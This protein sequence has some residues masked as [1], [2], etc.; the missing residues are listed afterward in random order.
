[1]I[2]KSAER[3]AA[4]YATPPGDTLDDVLQTMGMTQADLSRRMGRPLKTVNEI[5]KGK[6]AITPDTAL[7]LER[8]LGIPAS[9]WNNRERQY[10]G[11]LAQLQEQ[12]ANQQ[13][14]SWL[15]TIPV[16][17][18]V[19]MGWIGNAE[20]EPERRIEVL[21][22]FGVAGRR[23]WE[24]LWAAPAVSFRRSHVFEGNPGAVSAWL[25]RGE[26][27][28][29]STDCSK[30]DPA[31]FRQALRN[32]RSMTNEYPEQFTAKIGSECAKGGVA[33]AFVPEIKGAPMSG[34]TRWLT[35]RK[36]LIQLSLRYKTNDHLWFSLFHEAGHILLHGKRQVFIED[37]EV[38]QFE[39]EANEFACDWLLEPSQYREFAEAGDFTERA[40]R[41]F[42]E[43]QNIAPGIVVGRLQHDGL[44]SFSRLN[45]LKVKYRWMTRNS[46]GA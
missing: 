20:T 17:E 19:R 15:R 45:H 1:M 33:I 12:T 18:M 16:A 9:F 24:Q 34:A 27:L 7:Q 22:F 42:A 25:R 8:V 37:A 29:Q 3:Y 39:E 40:V 23:Q 43:S 38:D 26:I 14:R 35:P 44:I 11:Y 32:I 5:V 10:R 46:D 21:K 13:D 4:D 41:A 6:A 2:E 30:Y 28:A 31:Q 36:A